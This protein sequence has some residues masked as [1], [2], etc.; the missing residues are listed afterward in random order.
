ME[1][2][3]NF[4]IPYIHNANDLNSISLV[5]RKLYELDYLT[6]KHVTGHAH[7][8]PNPSRVSHRFP[9]IVSLTLKGAPHKD[10]AK[11]LDI[12]I[13][14][15]IKEISVKFKVLK[16]LRIRGMVVADEDLELLARTRGKDLRSLSIHKCEL[17]S[18]DG[19]MYVSKY[20]DELRT[21]CL[22]NNTVVRR[23]NGEWLHELALHNT[24][25]ETFHFGYAFDRYDVK[26]V[27]LLAKNCCNS[28]VSLKIFPCLLIDLGDAFSHAIKLEYFSGA[29]FNENRDY[30]ARILTPYIHNANDLNSIS[31]VSR[32]LYELDNLTRKH[33]TVH[34]HYAPNPSRVSHRFPF[35]ESLTLKG[36]PHK[37]FAKV[38]DIDI[39]PWIK[40]ISVKFKVLKALR[41]RGMVVADEDLE[42]LARTCGKDLRSLRIHKCELFSE[43]GL[44]YV[45]RYCNELRTLCL[46]NNTVVRRANGEWLR[47]LALHNTVIETFHFGYAFDRYDVKDV[48][49][50]AKNYCNSL[51]SLKIFPCLLIDL[52]DAFSHAIKLEYFSGALFNENGDYS[53]FKFPMNISG[54]CICYLPEASFPFLLPYCFLFES[55]SNLEV[56]HTEDICGDTGLQVIGVFCKKLRKL[57][58]G[59]QVTHMGLVALAQGCYNLKYLHVGLSDISNEAMEC[60]GTHLKNLRDFWMILVKKDGITDLPL[61]NGVRAMLMGCSKLKRLHISLCH[62]GLTDMGLGYIGKYG[63]TLRYLFLGCTGESDAGLLE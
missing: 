46:K 49:L 25:I 35:I 8:D 52:G 39:T 55:C 14:P 33:V 26:D 4:V 53:G 41:I 51:V 28:L 37:D 60:I 59:G 38:L 19:L 13:T 32:K 36:T 58:Y 11:V 56:L 1:Q 61:D 17:F 15:W 40:E 21:L 12:D 47:E 22:E 54:L 27:T 5:S 7:Y 29:L 43:D 34:T 62:G 48:T 42:L 30:S 18:E 2:V 45:S 31:L 3:F 24:V 50:L 23:A 9:F 57:T 63:H 16:A 20:C 10:F 6:R 44:M